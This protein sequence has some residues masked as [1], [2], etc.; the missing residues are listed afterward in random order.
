MLAL[1]FLIVM[2]L[3][4]ALLVVSFL[5]ILLLTSVVHEATI[6]VWMKGPSVKISRLSGS[7][8]R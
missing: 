3:T 1:S 6:P 4:F 8:E 2:L 5:A 7:R